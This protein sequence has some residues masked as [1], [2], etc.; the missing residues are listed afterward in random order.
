MSEES[1]IKTVLKLAQTVHLGM[2]SGLAADVYFEA[3]A[4]AMKEKRMRFQIDR[5]WTLQFRREPVG[6]YTADFLVNDKLIVNI[7]PA[8]PRTGQ[9]EW[10]DPTYL[11]AL[12]T[13]AALLLNFNGAELCYRVRPVTVDATR[14]AIEESSGRRRKR[15]SLPL[16]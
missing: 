10:V 6:D 4:V 7:D 12:P 9:V 5:T 2:G 15:I 13:E 11:S 3:M 14:P 16:S 1:L 8:P